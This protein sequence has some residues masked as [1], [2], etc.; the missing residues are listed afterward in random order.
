MNRFAGVVLLLLSFSVSPAFGFNSGSTGADGA[1]TPNVDTEVQLPASGILNYTTINI[2]SGVTVRFRRNGLNSPVTLLVSGDAT[3]AGAINISGAKAA[4]SYGAGS[5]NVADDG[6][7][8][9]GGPGGFAGGRGGAADPSTALGSPRT[10]QSGIGPGGGRASISNLDNAG[11]YGGSASFGTEGAAPNGCGSTRAPP[12]ATAELLPIVGGSGGAGGNGSVSTGGTGGGGGGGAL[13]LAVSG[14]LTVTGSI[15]A[16]GGA[17]GDLGAN[18]N[19][20][21]VGTVGGGGSGGAIRLVATTLTGNGPISAIGAGTGLHPNIGNQGTSG[22]GRIRL[23]AEIFS[24]TAVTTPPY[25]TSA[26]RA[27]GLTDVPTI[28]IAS[29][30]GISAPAQPT[31]SADIVLPTNAPATV[32]VVI[33]TAN[34]PLGTTVN[35]VTTPPSGSPSTTVSTALAGTVALASASANINLV[36]GPSVLLAT[37]SFSV[38]GAE[39]QTLSQF[40]DGEPVVSVELAA[41]TDG[42]GSTILVTQSGRRVML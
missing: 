18:Y 2:P 34:V 30:A 4:D 21:G 11:C 40:T 25:T 16:N 39:Q 15:L 6:L 17:G 28:R 13:L 38:A 14:T 26:P 24:R 33:E 35:I 19:A 23:E 3:I 8:G 10:G 20:T 32:P 9:V 1:L 42:G 41:G 5:G 22:V 36:D 31:G 29:V 7:P 37:V 27:L 12:Y